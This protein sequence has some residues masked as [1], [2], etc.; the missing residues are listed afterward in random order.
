PKAVHTR[1]YPAPTSA[2]SA[3]RAPLAWKYSH[4]LGNKDGSIIATIMTIHIPRNDPAASSH[5]CPG[6]RIQVMDML[7]PPG[8]DI[9]PIP[10]ME[11]HQAIV[12]AVLIVK[13]SAAVPKNSVR[14]VQ[15][16]QLMSAR[17]RRGDA[18]R[19]RSRSGPAA[20]DRATGKHPTG[21]QGRAHR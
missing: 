20:P 16:V 5:V 2:V 6:I 19:G 13:S 8:M 18:T 4:N 14:E 11:P 7:Q 1:K 12:T 3:P 17:T 15:E 9:S 10:D 21:H